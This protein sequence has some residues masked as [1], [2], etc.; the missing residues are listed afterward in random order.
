MPSA[1]SLDQDIPGAFPASAGSDTVAPGYSSQQTLSQAVHARRAEFTRQKEIRIKIGSWNVAAFKGTEKDIGG[2]FVEGKGIAEALSGLS[3]LDPKESHGEDNPSHSS[4]AERESVI[5]QE[6]R[7]TKKEPTIP[8]NDLGSVPGGD[9]IGLYVLGLQ[10][11]VDI[12]SAAEALRPYTDP[13]VANRYK[14]ALEEALPS[15]YRLIAE[16]Q[17]IGLLLLIYASPDV[18]PDIQS[19]STTSVGTGLMG[20][21]GNKGAVTARIVL[22]E[23][24]RLV[25]INSHLSA[26]ADKASLERRNWDADQ[27]ISRTRF[28]PII[29]SWGV[30]QPSSEKIG[31]EDFAFWFGDLNYRLEGMPGDDVRRLLMLHTRN[32]YDPSRPAA[33]KIEEEIAQPTTLSRTNTTSDLSAH[34]PTASSASS[35]ASETNSD[36]ASR[37]STRDTSI[38]DRPLPAKYDPAHLQTTLSSLLPHDELHQQQKARKAF[39]DGWREGPIEFLPT[40]KYDRGSVGV[41]DSSEKRRTPSWCDRILYRTRRDKLAYEN[42]LREEETARKRDDEMKAKG[43]D[44]ASEAEDVLFDYNPETDGDEYDEY[45]DAESEVVITKDGFEDSIHLEYYTAHQRVLSSDHKPLDAVF[46]LKYD[47]V[48]PELKARIHQEVARELDRAENEGRP[49]ITLIVDDPKG[50]DSGEVIDDDDVHFEGVNFRTIRYAQPKRRSVTIANTGRVPATIGFV[51]RPVGAGQ[52]AGPAPSYLKVEFDR[53]PDPKS[54]DHDF[55]A[56]DAYTLEP[57]EA[58]NVTLTLQVKDVQLIRDLNSGAKTLDD[59]LVLRVKDGRDH[60]LPIHGKWLETSFGR[61]ID[62]LI[63]IPEGGIRRL[64]HQK[65]KASNC[66]DDASPVKWSAPRELFRLTECVEEL[67]E[68]VVA[69]WDMV[70]SQEG[71]KPPWERVA[72]WPFAE[73]SWSL[74]D[75][76]GREKTKLEV[77]EALDCDKSFDGAFE[78]E[79]PALQKLEVLAEVLLEFLRSMEDGIITADLWAQLERDIVGREKAKKHLSLEYERTWVLEVMAAAPNHN[80]SLVLITSMLSRISNEIAHAAKVPT[81]PKK[82][83]ELPASPRANVRRRALSNVPAVARRQL[84]DLSLA[85]I[86]AEVVIRSHDD[87]KM[88]EKERRVSEER[89]IRVIE[90]FL[91]EDSS[92]T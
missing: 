19:V 21:M 5:E 28:A 12:T 76:V 90:I 58:V 62:K 18:A 63:R 55:A 13:A 56:Q 41:F 60:F 66:V 6:K 29:D 53:E 78:A 54:K 50:S 20:Y 57:G 42:R 83:A 33:K 61:S 17:L 2:W 34:S 47:A 69:E 71:E 91:K 36:R 73:E 86:F 38:D 51:D 15:G 85:S 59:I 72:G 64:Q 32:E 7:V 37:P 11:V 39:H 88:K 49:V 46:R 8:K 92:T 10:E 16:Q 30:S 44:E 1:E 35:A 45:A 24:T 89:R 26:G 82:D 27:I 74:M 79:T 77:Y 25:F 22:G 14:A 48:V 75:K 3:V 43:M 31:D 87:S 9:E 40:Y 4:P 67:V 65:P 81:E 84:V 70:N 52:S 23:T 80:V 68:R